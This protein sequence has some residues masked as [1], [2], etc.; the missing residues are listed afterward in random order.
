MDHIDQF[1]SMFKRAERVPFRFEEPSFKNVTIVVDGD[2]TIAEQVREQVSRYL[3]LLQSVETWNIVTGE[4]F[5]TVQELIT[6]IEQQQPDL[7]IT[8]RF[9]H[10]QGI[11]PQHSL[12]VYVDVLTQ[13]LQ[14]PVLLLPEIIP[15]AKGLPK[16]KIRNVMVITDHVSGQNKLISYG[17]A[18]GTGQGSTW[19]CQVEDDAVFE[20]Y[21]RA[22]E[23]I[24]EIETSEARRLI[25]QQLFNEASDYIETS[26]AALKSIFDEQMFHSSVSKGHRFKQ[27]LHLVE[28]HDVELLVFNTKDDDQLAMH[29]NSYA[30]SVEVVQIPLL[31]L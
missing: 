30:I 5:Q 17:A 8:K 22:I 27:Y 29:G 20:R 21:L 6:I 9:L 11:V 31:L 16:R 28:S 7:V 23:R 12:G 18:F 4:Q 19:I 10:E 1:S 14:P 26:I 15:P 24:P 13:V 3:P 2:S 25:Q